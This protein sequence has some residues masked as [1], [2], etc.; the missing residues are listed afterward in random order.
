MVTKRERGLLLV[1]SMY[2]LFIYKELHICM[3]IFRDVASLFCVQWFSQWF[4]I[5]SLDLFILLAMFMFW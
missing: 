3:Y 1:V 2:V 5:N 4:C